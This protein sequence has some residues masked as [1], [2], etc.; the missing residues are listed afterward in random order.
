MVICPKCH[1]ANRE[2][3]K[4]C[5]EC[6]TK[7]P[8]VPLM[9]A[10]PSLDEAGLAAELPYDEDLELPVPRLPSPPRRL[11]YLLLVLA[12]FVPLLFGT[13]WTVSQ[14]QVTPET[15]NAFK[16]VQ[17]L[18]SGSPV[19]VSFDFEP[20]AVGEMQPLT[21]AIIHHLIKRGCHIVIVS[22]TPQGP[23]LAQQIL[24]RAAAGYD[25]RYGRDYVNLGYIAGQEAGLRAFGGDIWDTLPTD[26]V[27]G[28]PLSMF[29]VM[30]RIKKA[31]SFDLLIDL[32]GG[33]EPARWW[34]EQVQT[35]SKRPLLVAVTASAEP[36]V[37]P[38]LQSGQIVGLV[39]GLPGAAEY[40]MLLGQPGAAIAAMDAQSMAH[41]VIV[42]C[43]LLG[44][45]SAARRGGRRG[46][47]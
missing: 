8:E 38:Y 45:L 16:A 34:I 20:G 43:L 35:P 4:F 37:R 42:L 13:K 15:T 29:S 47:P 24:R 9:P 6:G 12:V 39:R 30:T 17:N 33:P 3:S 19:L 36:N 32:A 11:I 14:I 28:Q 40:E 2:G 10:S 21:E 27:N 41:L 25:Y 26:Y 23:A 46:G 22:L 44:I 18:N 31:G 1:T 7:L 5:N